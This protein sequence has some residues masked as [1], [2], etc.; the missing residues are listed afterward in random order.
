MW[1]I[2]AYYRDSGK[3][4]S[5]VWGKRNLKTGEKLRKWLKRM[6]IS[7][8]KIAIDERDSVQSAFS[9]DKR[10]GEKEYTVGIA[11][12]NCRLRH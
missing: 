7:Y 1:F 5:F 9:R 12:N 4:V 8:D 11:G 6:G 10:D 3:V 2:Y